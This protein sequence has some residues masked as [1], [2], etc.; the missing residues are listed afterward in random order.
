MSALIPKQKVM[1]AL[2]EPGLIEPLRTALWVVMEFKATA[3][4]V[5]TGGVEPGVK[6][7]SSP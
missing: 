6:V 7:W 5:G 2:D 4:E 1:F 3:T